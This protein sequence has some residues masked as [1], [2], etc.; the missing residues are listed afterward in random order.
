[1]TPDAVDQKLTELVGR[2]LDAL[3]V[4]STFQRVVAESGDVL[5]ERQVVSFCGVLHSHARTEELDSDP[6]VARLRGAVSVPAGVRGDGLKLETLERTQQ[7]GMW[8]FEVRG[9]AT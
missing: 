7:A 9:S 2:K 1:M 5:Q 3:M 8:V 6:A 4:V